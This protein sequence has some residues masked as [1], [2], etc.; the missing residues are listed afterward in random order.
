MRLNIH[1]LMIERIV[2][3]I[4]QLCTQNFNNSRNMV[5]SHTHK[6]ICTHHPH[7]PTGI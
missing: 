2:I 1:K 7:R 6:C 5:Y 4:Q 3:I